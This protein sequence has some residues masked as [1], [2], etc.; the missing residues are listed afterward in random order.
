MQFDKI[1]PMNSHQAKII[2]VEDDPMFSQMI[3]FQLTSVSTDFSSSLIQLVSS[4]SEFDEILGF[5]LPDVILLDLNLPDSSGLDTYMKVKNKCPYSAVIILSGSDDEELSAKIVQNGAQDYILKSDVNGRLLSKSIQYSLERMRQQIRLAESERKFRQVFESSPIPMLTVKGSAF[6]IQMANRAFASLYACEEGQFNGKNLEELNCKPEE[7]FA[8]DTNLSNI[9]VQL[10][11]KT[12]N[13]DQIHVELTANKL[14]SES[15]VYICLIIDKTEELK[16]QEEKFKLVNAAQENEKHKIAREIHDG[17]AQNL[18]LMNLLFE[19]FDFS[20]EQKDQK[21]N[22]ANLIQNTIEEAR[23]ISYSLLP[24]E[25][26]S[27]FI[28]GVRNM[29]NRI[30]FLKSQEII[31]HIDDMVQEAHFEHVDRFNLFRI[32]QEFINNSIKHAKSERMNVDIIYTREDKVHIQVRD[33]GVGFDRSKSSAT[34]GIANMMNRIKLAHL[35]G[36]IN[37]EIGQGTTLD[38]FIEPIQFASLS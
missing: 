1:L 26:E 28:S 18:V 15:D 6:N 7:V 9:H 21:A 33:N 37:S 27:G 24:P 34:L 29:I 31:V 36:E 20:A 2:L 22:F 19:S 17:L 32:M 10:C 30:N 11:H 3:H 4:F 13:G 14:S 23:G 5:F 38:I 12:I 35:Q 16:F 8:I 25:L